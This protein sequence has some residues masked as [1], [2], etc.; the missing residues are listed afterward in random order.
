MVRCKVVE[1]AVS[2][3]GS[4]V[5]YLVN[6]GN[7]GTL[8][9][10]LAWPKYLIDI[11]FIKK[12]TKKQTN[13]LKNLIVNHSL[14]PLLIC[15][16]G[17]FWKKDDAACRFVGECNQGYLYSST[18]AEEPV[19]GLSRVSWE[20]V[21][22]SFHNS[23]SSIAAHSVI[24]LMVALSNR[25]TGNRAFSCFSGE[26]VDVSFH[27]SRSSIAAHSVIQVN[28][29]SAGEASI[30]AAAPK[31]LVKRIDLMLP[32]VISYVNA[33]ID[34]TAIGFKRRSPGCIFTLTAIAKWECS[35]YGRALALHA[36]GTGTKVDQRSKISTK[37][38]EKE[39]VCKFKLK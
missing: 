20:K 24:Q 12:D 9:S 21:D 17:N 37:G 14:G 26:K 10:M 28:K 32:V 5:D 6:K 33:A 13:M 16:A 3:C 1:G 27:N 29:S 19:T 4:E 39:V 34:T 2:Q 25:G 30:A 18:G 15:L 35:S 38:G 23:R 8:I 22:V 7:G 36:R 31:L 11:T